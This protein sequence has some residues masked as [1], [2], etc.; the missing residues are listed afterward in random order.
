MLLIIML[1]HSL[2]GPCPFALVYHACSHLDRTYKNIF[3]LLGNGAGLL[4]GAAPLKCPICV[5]W[6][7]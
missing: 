2:S 5:T 4:Y 7:P 6:T 3:A 1:F